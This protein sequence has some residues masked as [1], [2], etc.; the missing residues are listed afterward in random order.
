MQ[1]RTGCGGYDICDTPASA[2]ADRLAV[3]T[4]V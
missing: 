3:A 2:D 1:E 4:E